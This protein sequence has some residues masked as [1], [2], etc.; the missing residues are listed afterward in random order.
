MWNCGEMRF[1]LRPGRLHFLTFYPRCP[2]NMSRP[3]FAL[4]LLTALNVRSF[5]ADVPIPTPPPVDARSYLVAD[6]RTDK[7]LATLNPEARM[8]R[9]SLTKL[10]TAYIV[11]QKL[12]AGALKLD[13]PVVVSEHAWRSE[14]SR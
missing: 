3:L 7:P 2:T 11:F 13:E 4:L 5:G 9:A 14:G 1:L 8:E 6:Y 12:A 10:M